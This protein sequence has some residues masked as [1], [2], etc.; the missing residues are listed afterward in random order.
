MAVGN[1]VG[2]S[3]TGVICTVVMAV[4]EFVFPSLTVILTMRS[5][6]AGDSLELANVIAWIAL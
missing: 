3:F 1:P 5:P 4:F 6:A 2:S